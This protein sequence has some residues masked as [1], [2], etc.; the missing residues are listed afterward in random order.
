MRL[1][2]SFCS[3]EVNAQLLKDSEEIPLPERERG[4]LG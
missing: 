4:R 3:D 1:A 2:I